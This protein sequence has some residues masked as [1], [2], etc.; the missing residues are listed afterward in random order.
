M[1]VTE[2]SSSASISICF[3]CFENFLSIREFRTSSAS[4]ILWLFKVPE[5]LADE[6]KLRDIGEYF[7]PL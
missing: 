4:T 7:A 3:G 2:F 1:D 5:L 6:L